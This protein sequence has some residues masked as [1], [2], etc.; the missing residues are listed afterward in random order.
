[1]KTENNSFNLFLTFISFIYWSAVK[2]IMKKITCLVLLLCTAITWAQNDF[3]IASI[4]KELLEYSNS[5]LIDESVALDV[6]NINTVKTTKRRV[7]AVLNKMG[8]G[9]TNLYEY[10]DDNSKVKNIR[11][12][13]YNAFG[14]EIASFKKKDF[15]D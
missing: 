1:Q 8:N 9:D 2:P 14:K 15:N 6:T 11:V 5:V 12:W 10:Y 3:S 13:I 7:I 4:N